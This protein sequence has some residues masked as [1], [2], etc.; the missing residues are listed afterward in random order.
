M[1]KTH[2]R[3]A[4]VTVGVGALAASLMAPLH[5]G[6]A[7]GSESTGHHGHGR[8]ARAQAQARASWAPDLA[9]RIVPTRVD[10]MGDQLA[11]WYGPGF[12]GNGTACGSKLNPDTFGI[13]HRTLPC[14]T[15]VRLRSGSRSI[16][17]RVIDRGPFS[18][19]TVDLTARTKNFL[20]FTSGSVSM[21]VVKRYRTLPTPVHP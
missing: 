1:K 6:A 5:A 4:A 9:R 14:G 8:P 15:L 16:V 10:Q 17:V 18:G 13:A 3:I 20:G 7:D 12:W 11:T 21:S 19:A 2:A